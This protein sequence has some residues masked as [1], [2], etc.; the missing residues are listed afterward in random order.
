MLVASPNADLLAG[1]RGGGRY[2]R[3]G[4]SVGKPRTI[5]GDEGINTVSSLSKR[6][7]EGDRRAAVGFDCSGMS[8]V[9]DNATQDR[10]T[11][12]CVDIT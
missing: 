2:A 11:F 10:R 4:L 5:G 9:V 12:R 7:T 8:S 1:V 6:D 3:S